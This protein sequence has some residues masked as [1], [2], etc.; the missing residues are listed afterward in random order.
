MAKGTEIYHD[1]NHPL[2]S[3][4]RITLLQTLDGTLTLE[5]REGDRVLGFHDSV[6]TWTPQPTP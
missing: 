4:K 6:V 5:P 3:K 2:A 1:A